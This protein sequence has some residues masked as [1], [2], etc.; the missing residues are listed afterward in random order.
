MSQKIQKS[1]NNSPIRVTCKR[2][3]PE[4]P[5][6]GNIF[7]AC[8]QILTKQKNGLFEYEMDGLIFT[9]A[10]MGVGSDKV[11]SAGPLSKI[12]WDYSFKW[13]PPQYNTVDFLVTTAKT[14]TGDDVV[15]NIFE[16]GTS[17][18]SAVQIS[19]YKPIELRCTFVEKKHGFINPCQDIIDDKL[20]EY[21]NNQD[22]K[23]SN[24]AKPMIFYPT[25]P[26]DP[27]AGF[28]NIMLKKDGNNSLQMFTQ[29]DE[30]FGDNTIVEF[31]YSFDNKKGWNWIPLRVRYDKT[32]EMLQGIKNFG[33]A[34]HVANSN[35]QS[36]HHP[37]TEDMISTGL[38]IPET[39]VDEDV[40]YNKPSGDMKTE[41]LKNFHNLYVKKLLIKSVSKRDDT[42]I[43]YAC[44]KA[45][46]L[47]KWIAAKLSF[48]FGIDISKDNLENRIDGA[49]ARYLKARKQ[50]KHM[51]YA[52]FVNGNSALN[53]KNGTAMKSDKA[54]QITKAIFGHG[55]EKSELIGKGVARQYGVGAEGFNISSCQFAIHYFFKDPETL[56]GFLKNI[57]ECT[58]LNGY[59]IG[60]AYDGKLIYK[61][62]AKKAR[63]ENTQLYDNDKKIWEIVKEYDFDKFEDNSS[64]LGYRIDVYQ[65]S[66]NQLLTE[67]LIN[68]D[69]FNRVME[70]YGFKI[71]ER[72][73]AQSMGL[74]E[75]TG[76]FSELYMN[77]M[78]EIKANKFK[79][80]D[81]GNAQNMSVYEQKISFLNRYFVYKKFR[82]VNADKVELDLADY[83][84]DERAAV[85]MSEKYEGNEK[86]ETVS[87]PKI[88][89]LNKKILLVPAT[90]AVEEQAAF[91]LTEKVKKQ[92]K[93]TVTEAKSKKKLVIENDE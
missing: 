48:V 78:E 76:L 50:N 51:P 8:N 47:S 11:G 22:E 68:F 86:E 56:Q 91:K 20:P 81:Y 13:K 53:I 80:N 34:Y 1:F 9:P 7:S 31:S 71:I 26:Y 16:D 88:K 44:G 61:L 10:F 74:P 6:T 17:A 2:F 52:L 70:N 72:E 55:T 87:K 29:E 15:K 12:T 27:D 30:V 58:K 90:E 18:N 66:I 65:E 25:S 75:G 4:N 40:Y 46:D 84:D 69:Y 5:E 62:L 93:K 3:Y 23:V 41:G 45:G 85:E 19:Q 63:G 37:V 89:K 33:N 42:L 60:T 59:F 79:A 14:S 77:M 73:E 38:N 64:S 39:G 83:D 54:I 67:Y 57:A 43:D 35:W 49:C 36:I 82:T 92:T 32:S 28:C 24:E 21:N